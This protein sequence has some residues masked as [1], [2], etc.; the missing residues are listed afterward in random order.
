MAAANE[1]DDFK[2]I[3]SA[4]NWLIAVSN[5]LAE[6]VMTYEIERAV[7]G[8][9][10]DELVDDGGKESIGFRHLQEQEARQRQKQDADET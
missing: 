10:A 2:A 8:K 7:K 4:K 3:L 5:K 9:S 6:R 1:T